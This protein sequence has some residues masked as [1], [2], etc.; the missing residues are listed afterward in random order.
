ML[1]TLRCKDQTPGD[2][3]PERLRTYRF[4]VR[5]LNCAPSVLQGHP[6][7]ELPSSR[8]AGGQSLDSEADR[9]VLDYLQRQH[10]V[11]QSGPDGPSARSARG[12]VAGTKPAAH[13]S[14]MPTHHEPPQEEEEE[15]VTP[16]RGRRVAY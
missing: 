9:A 6:G 2:V 7:A 4:A 10:G 11:L 3:S 12:P 13:H 15:P 1:A 8:S 5:S 16:R 14:S